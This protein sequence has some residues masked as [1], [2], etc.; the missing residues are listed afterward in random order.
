MGMIDQI[1]YMKEA[2]RRGVDPVIMYVADSDRTSGA[3]F[4]KLRRT[5]ANYAIVPVDNEFVLHGEPPASYAGL[6]ALRIR[7]LPPFLKTYIDRPSFSFTRFL[8]QDTDSTSELNR[9]VRSNYLR[10]RD[11]ELNLIQ[12][13]L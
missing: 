11:I 9:W 3:T 5:F 1:G 2:D 4:A 8:R 12:Y 7:A 10:F 13:R 6:K